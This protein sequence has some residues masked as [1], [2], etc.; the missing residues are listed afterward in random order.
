MFPKVQNST[1]S[2]FLIYI[3]DLLATVSSSISLFADEC[4]VYRKITDYSNLQILQSDINYIPR[5]FRYAGTLGVYTHMH[6]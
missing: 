1:L 4:V 6:H 5:V 3:N 2:T